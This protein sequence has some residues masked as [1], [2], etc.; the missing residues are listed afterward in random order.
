MFVKSQI[1]TYAYSVFHVFISVCCLT[2]CEEQNSS[3]GSL[4]FS[5][6]IPSPNLGHMTSH[7]LAPA[8]SFSNLP[9]SSQGNFGEYWCIG[10]YGAVLFSWGGTDWESWQLH[11]CYLSSICLPLSKVCLY[12]C[13]FVH[14]HAYV[15]LFVFWF[16]KPN[17][18]ITID[19]EYY[20]FV[21]YLFSEY[22]QLLHEQVHTL[23]GI[24]TPI[25]KHERWWYGNALTNIY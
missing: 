17:N 4:L 6:L 12:V 23:Y 10:C 9:R 25:N 8:S 18:K 16:V 13:V 5:G 24:R 21:G 22:N 2:F 15:H 1:H 11:C 20:E 14:T 19:H 3:C 7:D